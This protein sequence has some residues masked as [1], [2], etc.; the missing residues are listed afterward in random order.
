[1]GSAEDRTELRRLLKESHRRTRPYRRARRARQVGQ[2]IDWYLSRAWFWC[3]EWWPALW[4]VA[5]ALVAIVTVVT[6]G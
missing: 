2:A 1:M 5:F 4:A 6:D 3:R